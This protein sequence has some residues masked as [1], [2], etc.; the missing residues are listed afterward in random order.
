M[1][2][3]TPHWSDSCVCPLH[4]FSDVTVYEK[5]QQYKPFGG[6]IQ[7][8][9]NALSA[10]ECIAPEVAEKVEMDGVVTGDRINGLLDG[11]AGEWFYR[12]DT[13]KVTYTRLPW[14]L[15][16]MD[17][18]I[19]WAQDCVALTGVSCFLCSLAKPT[20]CPSPLSS[21]ATTSWITSS[22]QWATT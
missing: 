2:G 7:L 15:D 6:P 9:C 14:A 17:A 10:L 1:Q 5:V 12:F 19:F 13:R 3:R 4:F 21:A 20:A 16:V 11:E 8:Q 18:A 22:K